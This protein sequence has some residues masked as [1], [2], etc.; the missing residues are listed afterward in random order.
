MAE[1]E[2]PEQ[3]DKNKRIKPQER[4]R[5]QKMLFFITSVTNQKCTTQALYIF[6]VKI[7]GNYQDFEFK[8]G[9]VWDQ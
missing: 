4:A 2:K 6:C 3:E 1:E 8:L 9:S 7:F 5:G